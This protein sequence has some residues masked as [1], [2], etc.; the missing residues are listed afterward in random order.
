MG[1]LDELKEQARRG[2]I[3]LPG[4]HSVVTAHRAI[5]TD[6]GFDM[7]AFVKPKNILRIEGMCDGP[8]YVSH[9]RCNDV[10]E[11]SKPTTIIACSPKNAICPVCLGCNSLHNAACKPCQDKCK[12]VVYALVT[13]SVGKMKPEVRRNCELPYIHY[14]NACKF[15]AERFALSFS[16]FSTAPATIRS[17]HIKYSVILLYCILNSGKFRSVTTERYSSVV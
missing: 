11:H 13:A 1:S 6:P 14:C 10:L 3:R 5:Y 15:Y 17:L 9:H 16:R 2:G 12:L 7:R 4:R 8:E